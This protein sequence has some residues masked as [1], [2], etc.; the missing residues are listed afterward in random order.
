[1]TDYAALSDNTEYES[2]SCIP[3][4]IYDPDFNE[5]LTVDRCINCGRI[6]LFRT[7]YT[8]RDGKNLWVQCTK[9][10]YEQSYPGSWTK[11]Q[12]CGKLIPSSV[13]TASLEIDIPVCLSC[14]S[15]LI[16]HGESGVKA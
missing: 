7:P 15:P 8:G 4:E 11:C 2:V 9:C 12:S 13:H 6:V 5:V 3:I 1:M 10:G 14:K 16:H